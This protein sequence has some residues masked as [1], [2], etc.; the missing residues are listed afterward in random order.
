MDIEMD[1][2]GGGGDEGAP[3]WMATFSDLATLLLT[4]FVLLLSFAEMDVTEFKQ[5][6]GSV[7]EAFGVQFETRGSYEARAASPVSLDG[8]APPGEGGDSAES[9]EQLEAMLEELGIENDVQIERDEGGL[10]IRI[11]ERVLFESGSADLDL[12]AAS[13]VLPAVVSLGRRMSRELAVQGHTDDRPIRSARFP[14]NW[15]LSASRASSVVRYLSQNTVIRDPAIYQA[16][17]MGEFRPVAEN[18]TREG[19]ARN[20]RVE[21]LFSLDE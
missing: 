1:D 18:T 2:D 21:I 3:A 8:E 17:G 13:E 16:V 15:E 11:R 14:S 5:M 19:R 4:F 12:S 6:L 9:R 7:R 10:T 20:R